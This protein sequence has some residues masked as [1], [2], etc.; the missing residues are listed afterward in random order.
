MVTD[1]QLQNSFSE[2]IAL[3]VKENDYVLDSADWN[4][5]SVSTYQIYYFPTDDCERILNT[6]WQPRPVSIIGW[7]LGANEADIELKSR[8]LE[9]FIVLQEEVKIIYNGYSLTFF[10][11]KNVK[12]ANTEKEDNEVLRKFQIEGVALDPK[13]YN[14]T[15]VESK[16]T[17]E[18][19]IFFFPLY[20]TPHEPRVVFGQQYS[21]AGAKNSRFAT[22]M[23]A[24]PLI[25]NEDIPAQVFGENYNSTYN[26]IDYDGVIATGIIFRLI[27]TSAIRNLTIQLEHNNITYTFALTGEYPANT[28]IVVDTRE[29]FCTVTVGGVDRTSDVA[30]GSVWFRLRPGVSIFTYFST[31]SGQLDALAETKQS[32]L[33]EVQT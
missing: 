12:F 8:R 7:V 3:G 20:F 19:P 18:V 23:F 29:G 22:S 30:E 27:S 11:T 33:F 21:N 9:A 15:T 2:I 17:Y 14:N 28:E 24:F 16:N 25:L 13:W 1:I 32:D 10:P 6:T 4:V 26:V 31:G 5:A